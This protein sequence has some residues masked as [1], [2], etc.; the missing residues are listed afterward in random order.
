M[1]NGYT[2]LPCNEELAKRSSTANAPRLQEKGS[3]G[4]DGRPFPYAAVATMTLRG[5][6]LGID[7]MIDVSL[8]AGM[9]A[10]NGFREQECIPFRR[11]AR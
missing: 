8:D 5:R 3:F 10:R 4:S 2:A 7:R 1:D 6:L 11:D 9:W